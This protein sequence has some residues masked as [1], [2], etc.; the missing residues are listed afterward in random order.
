MF[1]SIFSLQFSVLYLLSLGFLN[2]AY[3]VDDY[4]QKLLEQHEDHGGMFKI[5]EVSAT[6]YQEPPNSIFTV[7]PVPLV[8]ESESD[9]SEEPAPSSLE[10]AWRRFNN[11][12]AVPVPP[13]N[14]TDTSTDTYT[15]G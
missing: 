2:F 10:E 7:P 12:G 8:I 14:D 11:G 1:K 3:A 13:Q 9:E 15:N 6:D 5:E 4:D